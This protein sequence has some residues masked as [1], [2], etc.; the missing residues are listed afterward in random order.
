MPGGVMPGGVVRVLLIA[1]SL[2]IL[3]G[4]SVQATRLLRA[5]RKETSIQVDFQPVRYTIL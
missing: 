2:D 1:P 5:L 3:G 4:Q